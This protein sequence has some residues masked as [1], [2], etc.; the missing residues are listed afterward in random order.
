M[1]V[2]LAAGVP[3]LAADMDH[4]KMDHS[5]INHS[6]MIHD[7][8]LASTAKVQGK[9]TLQKL[10][11]I[12]ASGKA[13]EGGYD[14]R[15]VMESTDVSNALQAQCAQASRGLVM[16]DNAKWSRCGGK[17]DGAVQASRSTADDAKT[18]N[19]HAGHKM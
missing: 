16:M 17:P 14:S 18:M 8:S 9:A 7:A 15:Y 19:E 6:N 2:L 3:V 11:V 1:M 5:K 10:A 13:R 12:P 4:S